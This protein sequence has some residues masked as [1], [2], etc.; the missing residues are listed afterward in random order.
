MAVINS[1]GVFFNYVW[2]SDSD[3]AQSG[4]HE[5]FP[6]DALLKHCVCMQGVCVCVFS[7]G[8]MDVCSTSS[9]S[10]GMPFLWTL[11]LFE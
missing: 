7:L 5:G 9:T 11:F 3:D 6:K 8:R 10:N 2:N 1:W 4:R